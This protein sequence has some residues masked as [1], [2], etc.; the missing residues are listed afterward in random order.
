MPM[1]GQQAFHNIVKTIY[2]L[3]RIG[4]IEDIGLAAVFLASATAGWITGTVLAVDGGL[5]TN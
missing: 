2:P 5:T 3:Q 4:R 1:K